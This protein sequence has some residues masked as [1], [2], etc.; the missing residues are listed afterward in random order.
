MPNGD[1][2]RQTALA[3]IA[4]R[5]RIGEREP[6]CRND[7]AIRMRLEVRMEV[8]AAAAVKMCAVSS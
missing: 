8:G 2:V 3:P 5:H 7:V 6:G 4:I 1:M